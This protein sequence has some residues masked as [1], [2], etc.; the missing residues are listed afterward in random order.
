MLKNTAKSCLAALADFVASDKVDLLARELTTALDALQDARDQQ[1]KL[2]A[3]LDE[4][5][6]TIASLRSE[7]ARQRAASLELTREAIDQA[8]Q[9]SARIRDWEWAKRQLAEGR[10]LRHP[11]GIFGLR[12]ETITKKLALRSTTPTAYVVKGFL[13]AV[14]RAAID[15]EISATSLPDQLARMAEMVGWELVDAPSERAS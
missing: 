6:R 5:E 2:R 4:A 13:G 1:S 9:A 12:N 14:S 11:K 15:I 8:R 7:L 3:Q 10:T